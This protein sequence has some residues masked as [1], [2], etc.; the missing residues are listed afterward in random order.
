[1]RNTAEEELR[2]PNASSSKPT[3]NPN[4]AFPHVAVRGAENRAS[5]VSWKRVT[6]KHLALGAGGCGGGGGSGGAR[7]VDQDARISAKIR[8]EADKMRIKASTM[9]R[10]EREGEGEKAQEFAL[11]FREENAGRC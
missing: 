4:V 7:G 6:C 8:R 1:M 11:A 3:A 10:R 9:R 5:L 2:G